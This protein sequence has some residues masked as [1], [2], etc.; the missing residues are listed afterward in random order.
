MQGWKQYASDEYEVLVYTGPLSGIP[1]PPSG[2]EFPLLPSGT[3]KPPPGFELPTLPSGIPNLPTGLEIPALPIDI[4][5][6]PAIG[7]LGQS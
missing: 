2:I 6:F 7:G 4:P 3:P 5:G 1:K